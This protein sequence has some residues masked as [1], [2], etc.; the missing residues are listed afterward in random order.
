MD[1]SENLRFR[2]CCVFGCVL[3]PPWRRTKSTRKRTRKRRVSKRSITCVFGCVAFSGALC[4]PLIFYRVQKLPCGL[5]SS[6]L[7]HCAISEVRHGNH[8]PVLP[9]L[10]FLEFL[11]FSPCEEFLVFLSVF[12]F[13]SR[14]FRGSVGIKNPCFFGGF[15]CLFPK[16]QGKEGQGIGEFAEISRLRCGALSARPFFASLQMCSFTSSGLIFSHVG[17]RRR[18][19]QDLSVPKL[20]SEPA[21]SGPIPKNQI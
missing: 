6:C 13:F 4:S 17:A 14:D 16:K 5:A 8:N 1:R 21:G 20:Q 10:V 2:V 11:V 12:P 7:R 3:P 19:G 18:Y 15:P 9:F